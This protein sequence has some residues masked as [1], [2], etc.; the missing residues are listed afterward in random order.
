MY[1]QCS[2]S[3]E[4]HKNVISSTIHD[5]LLHFTQSRAFWGHRDNNQMRQ[6]IEK[7]IPNKKITKYNIPHAR[8]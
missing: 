2:K 8:Q 3:S 4:H 5:P 6:Y 1:V 7:K